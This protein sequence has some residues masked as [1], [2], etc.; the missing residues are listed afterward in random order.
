MGIPIGV[1]YL[2]MP[3]GFALMI[4]HL[5]LMAAPYVRHKRFLSDAE[6]DADA[7]QL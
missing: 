7:V 3:V 2:A 1:V 6:F 5:L 4:V